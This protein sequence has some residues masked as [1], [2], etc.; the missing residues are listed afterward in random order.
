[1]KFG[2]YAGVSFLV[3][4]TTIIHA[5]QTRCVGVCEVHV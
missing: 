5:W 2:A 4:V 3:A 1:M